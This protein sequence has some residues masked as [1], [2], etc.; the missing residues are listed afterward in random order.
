[1]RLQQSF[2]ISPRIMSQKQ[3]LMYFIRKWRGRPTQV[4]PNCEDEPTVIEVKGDP[5]GFWG[6]FCPVR[7]D[8]A[9]E[10]QISRPAT[11]S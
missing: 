2:L 10:H 4:V 7:S 5:E 6:H 3:T 11:D 9:S 1:M 8:E